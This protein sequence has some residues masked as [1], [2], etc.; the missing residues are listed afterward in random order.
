MSFPKKSFKVYKQLFIT[1]QTTM[2]SSSGND[3]VDTCTLE[4]CP[5]ESC[6]CEDCPCEDC[7]CDDDVSDEG[8]SNDFDEFDDENNNILRGKWIYDGSKTIDEMIECLH[9]EIKLLTDL[10]NDGWSLSH[11]VNDD[12]AFI[13]REPKN[14]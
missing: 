12:Y 3:E 10:K 7:S 4:D 8:A 1:T 6:P 14:V 9:R 2:T 11:E 13:T 5:C